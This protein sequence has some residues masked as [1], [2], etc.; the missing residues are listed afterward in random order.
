M[1]VPSGPAPCEPVVSSDA[2]AGVWRRLALPLA[3]TLLVQI[4]VNVALLSVAVLAPVIAPDLGVPIGR[5]GLFIGLAYLAGAVTSSRAGRLLAPIGPMTGSLVALAATVAGLLAAGA[6]A[7]GAMAASAV[8]LGFAYGLTT[9][10]SSEILTAVAPPRLYGRVFSI[11]QTAVPGAGFLAGLLAPP[12]AAAFGWQGA[13][14]VQALAATTLFVLFLPLRRRLDAARSLRRGGVR[15]PL[16]LVVARPRLRRLAAAGFALAAVQLS[17]GTFYTAYLVDGLGLSL[18]VGGALFALV[19]VMGVPARVLWGWLADR[20]FGLE[21]AL[22]ILAA[23]SAAG[24]AATALAGPGWPLGALAAVSV[25]LGLGVM[26]W[27]GLYLAAAVAAAPD[28]ASTVSAG[29]MVFT[30]A[31]VVAGPPLFGLA[32]ER[33]GGYPA[34]FAAAAAVALV[35]LALLTTMRRERADGEPHDPPPGR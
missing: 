18:A 6:G 15:S 22:A 4:T 5:A 12:L 35:A 26:A 1:R 16:R 25:H 23:L 19:Q 14:Q 32:V 11:K 27:T 3:V 17:L 21:R 8:L 7:L 31:G 2:A 30:F 13:L 9:P 34:G 33:L 10:T 24:L 29:A 28:D 20:V